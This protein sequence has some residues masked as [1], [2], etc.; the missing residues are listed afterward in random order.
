MRGHLTSK[1]WVEFG[2]CKEKE[3][4]FTG[5]MNIRGLEKSFSVQHQK[6]L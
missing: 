6:Y 4:S 3:A 1:Q 2:V 5:N